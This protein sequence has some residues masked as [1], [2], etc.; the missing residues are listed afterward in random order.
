LAKH[1]LPDLSGVID[2]RALYFANCRLFFT[3]GA[4]LLLMLTVVDALVGGQPF[5]HPE[6][7]VRLPAAILVA[8]AALV[9]NEKFHVAFTLLSVALFIAFVSVSYHA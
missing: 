3:L 9:P 5:V 8:L 6:N 2:P 1:F 7:A 4:I